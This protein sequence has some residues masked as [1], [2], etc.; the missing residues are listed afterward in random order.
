VNGDTL[1]FQMSTNT[2]GNKM[3]PDNIYIKVSEEDEHV[4]T[5]DEL[6][7]DS[8]DDIE[9]NTPYTT[10]GEDSFDVGGVIEAGGIFDDR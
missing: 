7:L 10:Y 8:F 4:P 1:V 9:Y 5:D 2:K 6:M 3:K